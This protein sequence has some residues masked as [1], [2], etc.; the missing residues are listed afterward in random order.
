MNE[1]KGNSAPRLICFIY[2]IHKCLFTLFLARGAAVREI[3]I[4]LDSTGTHG[5]Q[6]DSE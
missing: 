3:E 5:L 1:A 2:C 4:E 6:V